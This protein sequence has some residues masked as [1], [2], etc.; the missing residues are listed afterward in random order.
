MPRCVHLSWAAP[1]DAGSPITG[2]KL[3]RSTTVGAETLMANMPLASDATAFDDEGVT[4]GT[5]YYYRV[6]A[7]NAADEGRYPSSSTPLLRRCRTS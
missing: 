6:A 7:I 4:N 2:Y 5:T 3:Y 1:L